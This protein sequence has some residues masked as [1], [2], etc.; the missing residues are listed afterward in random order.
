M[1]FHACWT[2][3]KI[4]MPPYLF[5]SSP[6]V[7]SIYWQVHHLN[8]WQ[9]RGGGFFLSWRKKRVHFKYVPVLSN[10]LKFWSTILKRILK[11]KLLLPSFKLISYEPCCHWNTCHG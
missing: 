10:A 9:K 3:Y 11:T 7:L 2:L 6:M 5:K 4:I 1:L 8:P